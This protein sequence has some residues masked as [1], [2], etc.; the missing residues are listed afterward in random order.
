MF[1]S[2]QSRP[3]PAWQSKATSLF[4]ELAEKLDSPKFGIRQ[5]YHEL[6]AQ[7]LK[8]HR[9]GNDIYLRYV[10]GFAEWCLHQR[11][12]ELGEVTDRCFYR[13]LI[14]QRDLWV[15]I[16]PWLSPS[17]IERNRRPLSILLGQRELGEFEKLF[18]A[19]TARRYPES[20][21]YTRWIEKI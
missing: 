12:S 19:C 16:I 9:Q 15:R 3:M 11:E 8:A 17:V 1:G 7:T 14:P 5:L 21:Y 20:I 10:Y 4:P 13:D 18:A 6:L 2:F